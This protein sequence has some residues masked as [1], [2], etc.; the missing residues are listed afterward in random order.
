MSN[1]NAKTAVDYA[2]GSVKHDKKTGAV[3]IRTV[4]DPAQFPNMSW[5]VATTG[6][7]A[8]NAGDRDVLEWE[9]MYLPPVPES[10][11]NEPIVH[12]VPAA[13]VTDTAVKTDESA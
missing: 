9:D 3:A 10:Q 13:V 1:P 2:V 12:S 7:G 6:M 5:L 11:S 4:F 8:Q